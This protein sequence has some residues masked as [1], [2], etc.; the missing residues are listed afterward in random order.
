MGKRPSWERHKKEQLASCLKY[1]NKKVGLCYAPLG[2]GS[3]QAD[4][5]GQLHELHGVSKR[6]LVEIV[7][8]HARPDNGVLLVVSHNARQV[9]YGPVRVLNLGAVEVIFE[10]GDAER[11]CQRRQRNS[12]LEI[13]EFPEVHRVERAGQVPAFAAG[14]VKQGRKGLPVQ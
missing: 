12:A 9:F 13:A 10:R 5:P 6:L 3:G 2:Q 8:K 1:M 11:S 14:Q 7:Q 4:E